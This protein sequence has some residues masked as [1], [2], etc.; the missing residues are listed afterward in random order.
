MLRLT[1]L[2]ALALLAATPAL[3]QPRARDTLTIG[4]AQYPPNLNPHTG[5]NTTARA[6]TLAFAL[7]QMAGYDPDWNLACRLCETLPSLANGL[8][9]PEALPGGGTGLR[10]TYRLRPG[11]AWADGAPVTADDFVFPWQASRDPASAFLASEFW[12]RMLDVRA[13]DARTVSIL[14]E[15]VTFDFI[16]ASAF[17]PLR[18]SIERPRWEAD[19]A[20]YRSRS[21]YETEPTLPG[22]WHGPFRITAAQAG[23]GFTLERNP[24]W[25]GPGPGLR[26]IVIRAVENTTALEAQ[27][28]AGQIDMLG[29]LG[30][31]PD[32]AAALQRRSGDRFRFQTIAGL[33][34]ERIDLNLDNPLLADVRV[35]RA[36]LLAIDR[37]AIVARI[38]DGKPLLAVGPLTPQ[39]PIHDAT[40]P[41][42]PYDPAAAMALL[43]EAG[44]TPG[45]DGIRRN[46]AGERLAFD[47]LTT[48]GNRPREATQVVIQAMLKSVG[49]E[50]RPRVE[51]ARVVF[52]QS[53]QQRRYT[54]MVMV[55]WG[56]SPESVPRIRFHSDQIPSE[57]NGWTGSNVTGYRNPA[58][59]A[60]LDAIPGELDPQRRRA[61]WH[62]FERIFLA[63]L[64]S[65]PLFH[66]ATTYITPPWLEG[67][68][69]AGNGSA[70]SNW[71]EFWRAR[72]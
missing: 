56:T 22:L 70:T 54:G 47:L 26:R 37:G 13:E 64:P 1:A 25:S 15:R 61:L 32:Q 42:I 17:S 50:I 34:S 48:A 51:P 9:V 21:A 2:V 41:P 27:L 7:R 46:A 58:M 40:L 65:L 30:L 52:G 20:T 3:A 8:A 12:R 53:I 19:P 14:L 72:P 39:E 11:L 31:P 18:A 55:A 10:I 45:P 63:D 38:H 36:L 28:L 68:K 66:P 49:V 33:G 5:A 44:F 62:R 6:Y 71:A 29:T 69:P 59:D 23:T 67:V 57:A 43:E 16:A 35:R 4:V 60:V 24:H